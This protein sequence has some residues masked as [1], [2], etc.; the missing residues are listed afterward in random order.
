MLN[1]KLFTVNQLIHVA[2][3]LIGSNREW[4]TKCSYTITLTEKL[5]IK[6]YLRSCPRSTV[7]PLD[8]W[9]ILQWKHW[10]NYMGFLS[11]FPTTQLIQA[12]TLGWYFFF[13]GRVLEYPKW[14]CYCRDTQGAGLHACVWLWH[15]PSTKLM[16]LK[17]AKVLLPILPNCSSFKYVLKE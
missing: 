9:Q 13:T 6:S 17:K 7:L 11:S 8:Q 2:A 4:H 16:E 15:M 12:Q 3:A 14:L 1:L 5:Q 10:N